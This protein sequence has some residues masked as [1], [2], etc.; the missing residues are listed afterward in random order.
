MIRPP[1][2][3]ALR[4]LSQLAGLERGEWCVQ[5]L[6]A[7]RLFWTGERFA[8]APGWLLPSFSELADLAPA[9]CRLECAAEIGV[10]SGRPRYRIL[11]CALPGTFEE[12]SRRLVP[13]GCLGG[14]W[15]DVP[16][17]R[18]VS[19]AEELEHALAAFERQGFPR[20]V[21]KRWDAHY[22]ASADGA[23]VWLGCVRIDR[24]RKEA[25]AR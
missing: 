10:S 17:F 12:R 6:P 24:A 5:G 16:H 25:W 15:L 8:T 3:V 13:L 19:S 20:V 9:L 2:P 14:L 1:L 18:F 4:S 23:V 22:P 11:D 7:R 21:A